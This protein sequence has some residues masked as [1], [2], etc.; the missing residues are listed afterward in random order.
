MEDLLSF[1][2]QLR[3]H[4]LQFELDSKRPDALMVAV[5]V[6]GHRYEVEFFVDG[7]VEVERFTSPGDIYGEDALAE[8]LS[9]GESS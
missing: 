2:Q 9:F 5:F 8:V 7:H 4:S 3:D 6:P 1:L